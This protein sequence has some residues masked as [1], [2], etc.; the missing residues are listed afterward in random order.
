MKIAVSGSAG[1]GKTTLAKGL[2]NA[3]GIAYIPEEMRDYLLSVPKPIRYRP[4]TEIARILRT[5]WEKRIE[6]ES[7]LPAFVADNSSVDF[8]AYALYYGCQD[9]PMIRCLL[10]EA[11]ERVRTYDVFFVLPFG[12]IPYVDDGIR[13]PIQSSQRRYQRILESLYKRCGQAVPAHYLPSHPRTPKDGLQWAMK[14]LQVDQDA[15]RADAAVTAI[16]LDAAVSER[17][18]IVHR[19]KRQRI[20][21]AS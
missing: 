4:K 13:P 12:A 9:R 14:R 1:V 7:T 16:R 10:I 15:V 19:F 18:F 8:I 11:W 17:R 21:A 3:L 5:M 2:A 20:I 6:R